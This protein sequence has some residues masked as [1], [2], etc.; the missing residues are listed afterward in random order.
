MRLKL[1]VFLPIVQVVLAI[2]LTMSN[3]F[4]AIHIGSPPWEAPDSQLCDGL[5]AP[6]AEVRFWLLQGLLKC[7]P[8]DLFVVDIALCT[9]VYF[10]LIALLWYL[11]SLE[12]RGRSQPRSSAFT[13]S[14]RWRS[15]AD[16]F[17]VCFGG[18]IGYSGELVRRHTPGLYGPTYW[19]LVS[20]PYFLW[21]AVLVVFYGRDLWLSQSLRSG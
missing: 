2:C 5:N 19:T 13:F 17:L 6:A 21:A 14:L 16:V 7:L 20:V 10:A 9:V 11:V 12:I 1:T 4:R 18:L 3:H 8:R 15:L